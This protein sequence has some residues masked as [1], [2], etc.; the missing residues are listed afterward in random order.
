MG[1]TASVSQERV[2]ALHDLVV[3]VRNG[4][5]YLRSQRLGK[6]VRVCESHML[7]IRLAPNICRFLSEIANDGRPH[8]TEFDWGAVA[9]APFLPRLVLG[10]KGPG[11]I[12][13]TPARWSLTEQTITPQGTGSEQAR[14]FRGLQ[15][16]RKQWR[17]PRYVYLSEGDN[18][19]LLDLEHPVMAEVL[20]EKI[21]KQSRGR[22]ITLDELLP[23]FEHLWLHNTQGE[24]YF[25]EIVVPLLRADAT[26]PSAGLAQ[27][28][29]REAIPLGKN[30]L[31]FSE[32]I[33]SSSLRRKNEEV[34]VPRERVL[35]ASERRRFPGEDWIYLYIRHYRAMKH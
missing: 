4:H 29:Q 22:L 30:A 9:S 11:K 3:G 10:G 24:G 27:Q 17:V 6:Q 5:F 25:S 35:E 32:H 18:R 33:D 12:I 21:K 8:L 23:D 7:N 15:A 26:L 14:W 28:K 16:W 20:R 2:I 1:T 34:F 13:L 31:L 19:L